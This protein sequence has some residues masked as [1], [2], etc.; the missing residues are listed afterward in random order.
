MKMKTKGGNKTYK[1][2]WIWEKPRSRS[3][4]SK[5]TK[6]SKKSRKNQKKIIDTSER[7]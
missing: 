6:T 3:T 2:G 5:K 4:Q 7:T 1:A